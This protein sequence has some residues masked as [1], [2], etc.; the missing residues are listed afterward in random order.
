MNQLYVASKHRNGITADMVLDNQKSYRDDFMELR[1]TNTKS[2]NFSALL[3]TAF[4]RI[5]SSR[6]ANIEQKVESSVPVL[7]EALKDEED[8]VRW[9]S[10]WVLSR[11][12]SDAK[13]AVP[14][15][16]EALKDE[17]GEIRY[18]AAKTLESIDSEIEIPVSVLIE[19]LDDNEIY[20]RCFAARTL[21]RK[22]PRT[23]ELQK[24]K[25]LE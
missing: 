17:Q 7:I 8:E 9:Y 18:L 6:W 24:G 20:V 25:K 10:A 19:G 12:G 16:I 4:R 3:K 1:L 11:I 13:L 5:A 14:A 15:L 23:D 22:F 2:F 21:K